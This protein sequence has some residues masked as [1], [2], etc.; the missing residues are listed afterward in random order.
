MISKRWWLGLIALVAAIAVGW[1]LTSVLAQGG[2]QADQM[3]MMKKMMMNRP[4]AMK[5]AD[6]S[7]QDQKAKAMKAGKYS[8]CLKHPCD[9]CAVKMGECPCGMNAAKDMAVC[10]ECKGGWAVGDG[11]VPGKTADQ[12]MT[13]PRGMDMGMGKGK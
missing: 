2:M 9:H 4:G 1:S 11:I 5:K 13:M 3:E 7:I 12:I 8:C 6:Q 10:N